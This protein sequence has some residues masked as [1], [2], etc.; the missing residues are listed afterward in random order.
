MRINYP[1]TWPESARNELDAMFER[2]RREG[3]WFFHGGLSGPLWFSPDELQAKQAGGSFIWG[4]VNWD[5]R[6]P[7]EH[8]RD[9]DRHVESAKAER[10][11]IAAR[12]RVG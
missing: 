9:A 10:D 4:P 6:D 11:K 8:L 1:E 5:L 3:L 12:L 7:S 2:A